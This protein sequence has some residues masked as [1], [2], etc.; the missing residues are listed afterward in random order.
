MNFIFYTIVENSR[1][2]NL[3]DILKYVYNIEIFVF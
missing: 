1:N 3:I 2:Y